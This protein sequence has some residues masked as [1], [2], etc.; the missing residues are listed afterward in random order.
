M[1]NSK[2]LIGTSQSCVEEMGLGKEKEYGSCG[3]EVF[4]RFCVCV[5]RYKLLQ[6]LILKLFNKRKLIRVKDLRIMITLMEGDFDCI[7]SIIV[8]LPVF[9]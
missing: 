4:S 5:R 1:F 7:Q 6:N 8:M 2:S 3:P 9:S